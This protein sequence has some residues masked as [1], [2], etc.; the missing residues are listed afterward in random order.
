MELEDEISELKDNYRETYKRINEEL[1]L[2]PI[3]PNEDIIIQKTKIKKDLSDIKNITDSII[4]CYE[5]IWSN[6]ELEIESLEEEIGEMKH[7]LRNAEGNY[8]IGNYNELK[9]ILETSG[10]WNEKLEDVMEN[11]VR[12]HNV[13]E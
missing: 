6:K 3:I 9:R 10:V 7:E 13:I 8:L 5:D 2:V 12:F 1:N 4:V 11:I